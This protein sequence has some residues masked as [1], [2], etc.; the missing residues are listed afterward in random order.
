VNWCARRGR[1]GAGQD[2]IASCAGAVSVGVE[3]GRRGAQSGLTVRHRQQAVSV[4]AMRLGDAAGPSSLD[5]STPLAW[6]PCCVLGSMVAVG[7]R[8]RSFQ[9]KSGGE[10]VSGYS[11]CA[12]VHASP[13]AGRRRQQARRRG[14]GRGG[15]APGAMCVPQPSA[16]AARRQCAGRAQAGRTQ[17]GRPHAGCRGQAGCPSVPT[18][19]S[20]GRRA[21]PSSAAASTNCRP[22][23]GRLARAGRRR[24]GASPPV[25]CRGAPRGRRVIGDRPWASGR[26]TAATAPLAIE[27]YLAQHH[28]ACTASRRF[29]QIACAPF[30]PQPPRPLPSSTSTAGSAHCASAA[31]RPHPVPRRSPQH[32]ARRPTHELNGPV[33]NH[34]TLHPNL[35]LSH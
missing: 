30:L 5:C 23:S 16:E 25:A 14:R 31:P 13:R 8:A 24:A 15:E 20:S 7:E 1:S 21:R 29:V 12:H 4:W 10:N 3:G 17:G 35:A 2:R 28:A 11:D 27:P 9:E 32:H 26:A 22:P 6:L 34:P 18:H 19:G 33:A